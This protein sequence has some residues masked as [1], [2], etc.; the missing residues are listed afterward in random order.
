MKKL[1]EIYLE[2]SS[3]P[4]DTKM[5][6][7]KFNFSIK[8]GSYSYQA[9]DDLYVDAFYQNGLLSIDSLSLVDGDQSSLKIKGKLP[10]H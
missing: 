10:F 8:D 9:F 5:E 6:Q 2:K 3:F 7:V 4:K 1:K